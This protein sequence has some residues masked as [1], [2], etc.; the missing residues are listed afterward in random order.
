MATFDQRHQ[1]VNY[2]YNAAGNINLGS[3]SDRLELTAQL[4][5]IQDELLKAAQQGVVDEDIAVEADSKIKK[6]VLQT[7]KPEPDKKTILDSLREAQEIIGGVA[8]AAGL[9]KALAEAIE[10]VQRLF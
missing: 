2:Q 3:V 8:A 10:V 9:F 6:A 4:S 1:K 7:K 5:N